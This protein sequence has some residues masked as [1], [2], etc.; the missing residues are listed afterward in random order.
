MCMTRS[1]VVVMCVAFSSRHS[2]AQSRQ[3]PSSG[4]K[5]ITTALFFCRLFQVLWQIQIFLRTSRCKWKCLFYICT[6]QYIYPGNMILVQYMHTGYN[7][8]IK[9]LRKTF[10]VTSSKKDGTPYVWYCFILFTPLLIRQTTNRCV[11]DGGFIKISFIQDSVSVEHTL[12]TGDGILVHNLQNL[13][14][15]SVSYSNYP[16]W[17][18]ADWLTHIRVGRFRTFL[19]Y[20]FAGC[21]MV[22]QL[23][24]T[25]GSTKF[26][27][28][29][30]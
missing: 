9:I 8:W 15:Q 18:T 12:A 14:Q 26:C 11:T 24:Q 17:G 1:G 20:A 23:V 21:L 10:Y 30:F 3:T 22:H 4:P 29:W 2:H 6:V 13:Y 19:F 27:S 5:N 7:K 16:G 28:F 25:K